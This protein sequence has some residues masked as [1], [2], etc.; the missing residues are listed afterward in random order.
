MI[1]II[2]TFFMKILSKYKKKLAMGIVKHSY[3]NLKHYLNIMI[4]RRT[5]IEFSKLLV[6]ILRLLL[7]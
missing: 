2:I 7:S 4:T 3:D 6:I 5:K 1:D